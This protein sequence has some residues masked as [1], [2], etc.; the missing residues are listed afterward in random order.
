MPA[1]KKTAV[2]GSRSGRPI[3]ALLDL[4][5]RRWALRSAREA[6][7][8]GLVEL[9]PGEGYRLA[10]PGRDMLE[11]FAPLHRFAERWSRRTET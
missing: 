3:M 2:R 7:E 8:A 4:L 1:M 9:A 5:S 10:G 6:R 11:T